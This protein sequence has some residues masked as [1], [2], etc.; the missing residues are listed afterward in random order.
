MLP[1]DKGVLFDETHACHE[2]L[3]TKGLPKVERRDLILQ[4]LPGKK[5]VPSC[6]RN[7]AILEVDYFQRKREDTRTLFYLAN[8]YNESARWEEAVEFYDKYLEVATWHEE[9]F[10]AR[11]YKAKALD[12]IDRR[13]ESRKE[14]F[15]ALSEDPRFAEP[16]CFLGDMAM[17]D[18]DYK[19]AA[20]WFMMAMVTPFPTNARLFV[21]KS[22][23]DEYPRQRLKDCGKISGDEVTVMRDDIGV[24]DKSEPPKEDEK[25]PK[26][27]RRYKL[28]EDRNEAFLAAAAVA[29]CARENTTIQFE[30]VPADTWQADMAKT[31]KLHVVEGDGMKLEV[32]GNMRSRHALEWYCRSAGFMVSDWQLPELKSQGEKRV[33]GAFPIK[34]WSGEKLDE[35]AKA[36]GDNVIVGN[37]DDSFIDVLALMGSAKMVVCDSGWVQHLA[38]AM[39]VPAV[40][41]WNGGRPETEGWPEN[42]NLVAASSDLSAV[43]VESV[44]SVVEGRLAH[45]SSSV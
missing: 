4:H 42:E 9:R 26:E 12:K 32:P 6:V 17:G 21:A 40:V 36:V 15:R 27:T 38:R 16:Y 29:V 35:L 31:L 30:V 33:V 22:M 41:L 3:L 19:R 20:L 7:L 1:N 11:F 14:A 2:F 24:T 10:F 8:A 25:P 34:G 44:K 18:G 13:A 23:Y 39:N 43:K 5:G 37:P 45:A 28:P